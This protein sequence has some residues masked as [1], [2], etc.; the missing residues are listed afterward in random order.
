[1]TARLPKRLHD[2]L[3]KLHAAGRSLHLNPWDSGRLR[4]AGMTVQARDGC[5]FLVQRDQITPAGLAY[6]QEHPKEPAP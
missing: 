6:C 4:S 2:A 5:G 1:M 3:H